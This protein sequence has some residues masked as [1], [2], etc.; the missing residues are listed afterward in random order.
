MGSTRIEKAI[1]DIDPLGDESEF[2][3]EDVRLA[4]LANEME[5][6]ARDGQD[7]DACWMDR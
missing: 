6:G 7:F 2:S 4:W 3:C 5:A 1:D